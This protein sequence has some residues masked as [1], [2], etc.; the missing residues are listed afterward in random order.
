[1]EPAAH[2]MLGMRLAPPLERVCFGTRRRHFCTAWPAMEMI[3]PATRL[4]VYRQWRWTD[5]YALWSSIEFV[6]AAPLGRACI[7]P[8]ARESVLQ[9]CRGTGWCTVLCH[10]VLYA[11]LF[12]GLGCSSWNSLLHAPDLDVCCQVCV[13]SHRC[14][15]MHTRGETLGWCMCCYR[16]VPPQHV[17]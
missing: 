7:C 1:M 14:N 8:G 10:A 11:S 15:P 17:A 4:R 6:S 9:R 2:G 5:V 12:S 13:P 3:G 16:A